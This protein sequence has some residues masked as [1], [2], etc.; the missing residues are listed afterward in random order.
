M[1]L[2]KNP[3]FKLIHRLWENRWLYTF[4]ASC[5]ATIVG[6]SLT[7]GINSCREKRRARTEARES[8]IQAVENLH[9]RSLMIDDYL[10]VINLQDSLSQEVSIMWH[11]DQSVP[12]S[13]VT[14]FVQSLFKIKTYPT[15]QSFE[16]IFRESFQL[17]EVLDQDDLTE[18]IRDA[19]ITTNALEEY[20]LSHNQTLQQKLEDC[21]LGNFMW[22]S[23]NDIWE[24]LMA[25]KKFCYYMAL[26]YICT[27][28]VNVVNEDHHRDLEKIDSI[29][30]TLDYPIAEIE[31][32]TLTVTTNKE[33]STVDKQ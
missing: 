24:K 13:V 8:I 33:N 31:T 11:S 32:N 3:L 15:D 20:C 26:R 30:K 16:K 7:F 12:D 4:T 21:E 25:D 2:R 14:A 27:Q 5:T 1:I 29:C 6:I 17:W 23:I 9:S 22:M 18:M 10:E 19:Y 28:T